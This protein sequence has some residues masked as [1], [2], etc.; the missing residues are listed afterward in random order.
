MYQFAHTLLSGSCGIRNLQRMHQLAIA[1]LGCNA[2]VANIHALERNRF[3]CTLL[4][5][6]KVIT[7]IPRHCISST[8]PSVASPCPVLYVVSD[9][10]TANAATLIGKMVGSMHWLLAV[11]SALHVLCHVHVDVPI[12][13]LLS[14]EAPIKMSIGIIFSFRCLSCCYV[15]SSLQTCQDEQLV[16]CNTPAAC[17]A[18]LSGCLSVSGCGCIC[19]LTYSSVQVCQD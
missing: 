8:L 6:N 7:H 3:H 19:H 9:G 1:N 14:T 10:G 17:N 2:S 13:T 15:C 11:L 18:V 16:W 4:S 5:F 12:E